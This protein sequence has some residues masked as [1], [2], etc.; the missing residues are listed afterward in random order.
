MLE[1]NWIE[2]FQLIIS[3]LYVNTCNLA[4]VK[5]RLLR[6][7]SSSET[8]FISQQSSR[9]HTICPCQISSP[10]QLPNFVLHEK[11][12]WRLRQ[13]RADRPRPTP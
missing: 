3:S 13:K 5:E 1:L 10:T 6:G 8:F 11:K 4:F 7:I 2:G 12:G 9:S